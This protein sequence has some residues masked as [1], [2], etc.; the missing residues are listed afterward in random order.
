[1][2]NPCI[3]NNSKDINI[4]FKQIN[5]IYSLIL[6][7][8]HQSGS[9]S[10]I[11][12]N[13]YY[14]FKFVFYFYIIYQTSSFLHKISVPKYNQIKGCILKFKLYYNIIVLK[15]IKTIKEFNKL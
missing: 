3:K 8:Y 12:V 9:Y 15:T 14:H 5:V 7:T 13:Y 6:Q 2:I 4:P 1:M 10:V 11:T